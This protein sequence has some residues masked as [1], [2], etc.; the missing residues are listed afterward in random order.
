M[1]DQIEDLS[2]SM[3]AGC[4][5]P[6]DDLSRPG[7]RLGELRHGRSQMADGRNRDPEWVKWPVVVAAGLVAAGFLIWLIG[8]WAVGVLIGLAIVGLLA[9]IFVRISH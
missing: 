2:V 9:G 6:V 4:E 3:P 8:V 5:Q 7:V 1:S